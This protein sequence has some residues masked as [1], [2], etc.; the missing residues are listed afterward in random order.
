MACGYVLLPPVLKVARHYDRSEDF[1]RPFGGIA[2]VAEARIRIR[3]RSC[4]AL[5]VIGVL[6]RDGG[7]YSFVGDTDQPG[8]AG[9]K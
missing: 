9:T 8:G 6:R 2:P 3:W 1:L 5:E 7:W 4:V